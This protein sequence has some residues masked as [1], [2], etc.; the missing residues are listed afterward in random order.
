MTLM[1]HHRRTSVLVALLAVLPASGAISQTKDNA[2]TAQ[3]EKLLGE[4]K[5]RAETTHVYSLGDN[6]RR[7]AK[8]VPRPIFRYS[9][10][11]LQIGAQPTWV[12]F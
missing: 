1:R 5:T 9:D 6:K 12:W 8:L 10:E 7:Q 11:P 2:K 3:R 4:M